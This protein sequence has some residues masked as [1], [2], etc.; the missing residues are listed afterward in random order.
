VADAFAALAE[1]IVTEAIPLV[2][3]TG[4]TARMLDQVEV[5]LGPA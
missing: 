5:A 4:C 3:M 1:R 2:E